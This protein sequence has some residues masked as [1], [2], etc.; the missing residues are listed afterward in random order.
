MTQFPVL[1]PKAKIIVVNFFSK[2]EQ[3]NISDYS[4]EKLMVSLYCLMPDADKNVIRILD[5]YNVLLSDYMSE[6]DIEIL[7]TEYP[8]VVKCCFDY[9]KIKNYYRIEASRDVVSTSW[10]FDGIIQTA[11]SYSPISLC[12]EIAKPK[13]GSSVFVPYSGIGNF[14]H[15]IPD[16]EIDGFEKNEFLWAVSQII[17][18]S[19][20]V[21]AD[22]KMGDFSIAE[23]K[24]YDYIF[25]F[26][27]I[28]RF[29]KCSQDVVESICNLTTKHL[30]DDGELYCI[31]P[32]DFS[33]SD[34]WKN[35]RELFLDNRGLYSVTTINFCEVFEPGIFGLEVSGHEVFYD[36]CILVVKKNRED[37]VVLMDA[38]KFIADL[39]C[40]AD[41]LRVLEI[42][43]IIEYMDTKDKKSKWTGTIDLLTDKIDLRPWT[44]FSLSSVPKPKEGEKSYH[45]SELVE[46]LPLE[47]KESVSSKCSMCPIISKSELSFSYLNCDI[48]RETLLSSD[49][50]SRKIITS[51][52]ARKCFLTIDDSLLVGYYNG[53]FK[54]GRIS[55][56]SSDTPVILGYERIF[57]IK[58]KTDKITE[59]FFLRSIMS[60]A[61]AK[62]ARFLSMRNGSNCYIFEQDLYDIVINV[63]SLDKQNALWKE[64][65]KKSLVVAERKL[66]KSYDDFRK[67]I[68]MKKHAIGQTLANFKNW[69]DLLDQIRNSGNGIIDENAIIGRI[70]KVSVREIFGNLESSVK[71]LTTQINSFDR[72][73]G[74]VKEEFSLAKFIEEYIQK[75]KSPIFKYDNVKCRDSQDIHKLE[76]NGKPEQTDK[77]CIKFPKQALTMIF[78][79]I[80]SNA[81]AH[82]FAGR[83]EA[84]NIIKIDI[85]NRG[86]DYIVSISNNG[87]PLDRGMKCEEITIYGHTSGDTNK[88]WGIGGYEIKR[89]M[90]EFGDSLEI[91]SEPNAEFTVIYK[92]IFHDTN[93][94]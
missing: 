75:H 66:H 83:E 84:N 93:I 10:I 56:V 92:L 65:A 30:S 68:H 39:D 63:P 29:D 61:T 51:S 24:Q 80:V 49:S 40:N 16:C 59:D 94:I 43:R 6:A 35:V 48:N 9:R 8:A 57:A 73:Y 28:G 54:V 60:E 71:K 47:Y 64:D 19:Q 15:Y 20:K 55:G 1:S 76:V 69:W 23:N 79:N 38:T 22:I 2:M 81:C 52:I 7:K 53:V 26:P 90:E 13:S 82:G 18:H 25:C 3:S 89:L 27:K 62:Q 88:H 17:L 72:G 67:D 46:I 31:L 21:V 4:S 14:V 42:Q 86:S 78:D 44:Y 41:F 87:E 5:E 70:R 85:D 74:M 36:I 37:S 91:I 11:V 77:Y 50:V 12:M 33:Y 58:L 45:L 32:I 34:T